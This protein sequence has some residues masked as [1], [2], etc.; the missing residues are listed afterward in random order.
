MKA[1]VYTSKT[2][3]TQKYA[4]LLSQLTDLPAYDREEATQ[5][6]KPG[7]PI[8]YMGWIMA[9]RIRGL[10]SVQ[11]RYAVK[12]ICAIGLMPGT[13]QVI[14]DLIAGN[15]VHK[16]RLFYLQ[17]GLDM[18]RLHGPAKWVMKKVTQAKAAAIRQ[19][20][21]PSPEEQRLLEVL[22]QG[23]DFISPEKL[24]PVLDFIGV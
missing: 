5:H 10:G 2:G 17:G 12:A 20:E 19:M 21:S 4:L 1:I 23:G 18:S 7:D 22:E 16:A 14:A 13:E 8:L 6:L 24:Q 3:F 11:R 9:G 15:P